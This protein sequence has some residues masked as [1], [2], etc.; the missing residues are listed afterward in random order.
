MTHK[1][2]SWILSCRTVRNNAQNI[3]KNKHKIISDKTKRFEQK[4]LILLAS[5]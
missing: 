5:E 4:S 2:K 1:V 3:E